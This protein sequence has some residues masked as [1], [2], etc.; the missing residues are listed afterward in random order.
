[1]NVVGTI[2]KHGNAV[3]IGRGANFILPK[4]R[5]FRV[6]VIA[7]LE[8]RIQNVMQ[9]YGTSEEET[10]RRVLRTESNRHAFI[11]K[12]FNAGIADPENYDFLIN[13]GTLK[14]DAAV[15]AVIGAMGR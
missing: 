5:M 9:E 2:G 11:R 10:K 8:L 1:M 3:I 14:L 4:E 7:P 6:R 12:Y 15:H 13:T